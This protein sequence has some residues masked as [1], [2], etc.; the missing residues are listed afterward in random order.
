MGEFDGEHFRTI[1]REMFGGDVVDC[2]EP[3]DTHAAHELQN[4]VLWLE[5]Q[6]NHVGHRWA[7]TFAAE[8]GHAGDRFYASDRWL[9]VSQ[10][11]YYVTPS[12]RQ[13]DVMVEARCNSNSARFYVE[14]FGFGQSDIVVV[15]ANATTQYATYRAV[16]DL[17]RIPPDVVLSTLRI[18]VQTSSGSYTSLQPLPVTNLSA[19]RSLYLGDVSFFEPYTPQWSSASHMGRHV[20]SVRS[21]PNPESLVAF[22][23]DYLNDRYPDAYKSTF[24]GPY[25][26]GY[27]GVRTTEADGVSGLAV[28]PEI[29]IDT[30][31]WRTSQAANVVLATQSYIQVRGYC[32][33]ETHQHREPAPGLF[34]PDVPVR[35]ST[36]QFPYT[37]LPSIHARPR[38]H[39]LHPRGLSEDEGSGEVTGQRQERGVYLLADG[40]HGTPSFLSYDRVLLESMKLTEI[41]GRIECLMWCL[42]YYVQTTLIED[43]E[44]LQD[45]AWSLDWDFRM[46]LSSR[47]DSLGSTVI[48][49]V[50]D[51]LTFDHIPTSV[52]PVWPSLIQLYWRYIVDTVTR[53]HQTL[54]EG[55]M[56]EVDFGLMTLKKIVLPLDN[57]T[58]DIR[59]IPLKLEIGAKASGVPSP[60]EKNQSGQGATLA[61]TGLLI[62]P[63]VWS[64]HT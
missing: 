56:Y 12:L 37:R 47:Q 49:T 64:I 11:A 25:P 24:S 45:R 42:P 3:S 8:T 63:S 38:A 41:R 4:Q 32:V 9:C 55:A 44:E 60:V 39:I 1:H 62:F 46:Q 19:E 54:K 29:E 34:R 18:W 16:I 10:T 26:S 61:N 27:D 20:I 23:A 22:P 43:L 51:I 57:M 7:S 5:R 28:W 14:L 17:D 21:L 30:S 35:S 40:T 13:L 2:E 48:E 53:R 6:G 36:E 52:A 33:D 31:D 59:N 58:T 15:N 50:D